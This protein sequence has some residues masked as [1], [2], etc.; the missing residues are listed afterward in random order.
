MWRKRYERKIYSYTT[1]QLS[2][3]IQPFRD[4]LSSETETKNIQLLRNFA[5]YF[6]EPFVDFQRKCAYKI[7]IRALLTTGRIGITKSSAYIKNMVDS[8]NLNTDSVSSIVTGYCNLFN[9]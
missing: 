4:S 9:S 7:L 6:R 8:G 5:K 2:K 1:G 3:V